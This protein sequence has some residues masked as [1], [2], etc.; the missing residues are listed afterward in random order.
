MICPA[1]DDSS[2]EIC[3]GTKKA[4]H[5]DKCAL[6]LLCKSNFQTIILKSSVLGLYNV[7]KFSNDVCNATSDDG[8]GTCFTST[9]C[10]DKV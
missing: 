3:F 2:S 10:F 9:E 4:G 6:T 5:L 1:K 7:A 8:Q